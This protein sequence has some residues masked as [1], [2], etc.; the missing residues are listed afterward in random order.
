ML[1]LLF[2]CDKDRY[3]CKC[4]EV[5]EII[6]KVPLKKLSYTPS[7]V[8]GLL[9]Y[10]GVPIPVL[11]WCQVMQGKECSSSMHSR[12]LIIEGTSGNETQYP[13]G[14]MAEKVIQ[15]IDQNLSD[16][17]DSHLNVDKTPYLGGVL[18][19]ETGIIQFVEMEKLFKFTREVL[20]A[21]K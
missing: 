7:Y 10:R 1:M 17:V 16:F 13:F 19:D 3:A 6:P 2:Y 14:V 4:S 18:N 9:N 8:A 12:I 11:D 21:G 15:T 5:K 20:F